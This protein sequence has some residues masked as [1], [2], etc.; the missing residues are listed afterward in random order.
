[1]KNFVYN[2]T[3]K[4]ISVLLCVVMVISTVAMP[5]GFA[6]AE[7]TLLAT[8]GTYLNYALSSVGTSLDS[9]DD[10][11]SVSNETSVDGSVPVQTITKSYAYIKDDVPRYNGRY[12]IYHEATGNLMSYKAYEPD[13]GATSIIYDQNGNSDNTYYFATDAE[14]NIDKNKLYIDHSDRDEALWLLRQ[15]INYNYGTGDENGKQ[16][17]KDLDVLSHWSNIHTGKAMAPFLTPDAIRYHHAYFFKGNGPTWNAN[18]TYSTANNGAYWY[19]VI[20]QDADEAGVQERQLRLFV[21]DMFGTKSINTQ[22]EPQ[23]DGTFIVFRRDTSVTPTLYDML[24]C[25]SD[26]NWITKAVTDLDGNTDDTNRDQYKLSFY[27]YTSVAENKY[28]NFKGYQNYDVVAGTSKEQVI[29]SIMDNITVMN[30]TNKNLTIPCSGDIGRV[31]YYW[32]DFTSEYDSSAERAKSSYNVNIKYRN[33]DGS[34]TIVGAVSVDVH[35]ELAIS[36]TSSITNLTGTT[37][38]NTTEGYIVQNIVDENVMDCVFTVNV[39]TATGVEERTVPVTIGMLTNSNGRAVSTVNNGVFENLTLTYMGET[40]TDN[41]T[42]V[43]D[44]SDEALNYPVYPEKGSVNVTKTG[45]SAGKFNET[46]VANINLSTTGV[47]LNKG[48]DMIV[49]MDL[50]G[51][52]SYGVTNTVRVD[53]TNSETSR[54]FALQESLK[55]MITTLKASDIDYRIAMSD[56]GDIDSYE[57]EGAVVDKTNPV[58]FFFD[59]D[60]DGEWDQK[61]AWAYGARREFY[62]HLNYVF[63]TYG[64]DVTDSEGNVITDNDNQAMPYNVHEKKYE[65]ALLNYSGKVIPN[66]YTGSHTVDADAFVDVDTFD[67]ATIETLLNDVAIHQKNSLGTNYDVGLEYAYQLGH[68]IQERNIANGEDRDIICIFMSDGAAMQYNYFSGRA[69]VQ[70]W[71]DWLEGDIDYSQYQHDCPTQASDSANLTAL[72]TTLLTELKKGTLENPKYGVREHLFND[73][74]VRNSNNASG[75]LAPREVSETIVDETTGEE[76]VNV[77]YYFDFSSV[78]VSDNDTFYSAMQEIG[79]SLY[80]DLLDRIAKANGLK[81]Y[82]CAADVEEELLALAKANELK[83]PTDQEQYYPKYEGTSEDFFT[84]MKELGIN[85]GWELFVQIATENVADGRLDDVYGELTTLNEGMNWAT[86]S[87]YYYFYNEDGK[88]WFAEA[89]KGDRSELYPVVNKHAFSN[90]TDASFTYYGDVRNNYSTDLGLSLDGKDYISGFRG[91]DIP[92]YTVGLSLCT[93]GYLSEQIAKSVLSNISSGPSY[94]FTANNK[95]ELVDVFNTIS[96]SS[97]V[98]ATGAYFTDKMGPEFDLYTRKTVVNGNGETVTINVEPQ[99]RVLEYKLDSNGERIGSPIVYETVTISEDQDGNLFVTSDKV[100]DIVEDSSG[101]LTKV[102][103]NIISDKG[104][105]EAKYFYYNTNKYVD[106][107]TTGTVGIDLTGDKIE[108]WQLEAETFFWIIGPIS[109]TEMVLDYQVYLTGSMEGERELGVYETNT[110]ATL[111]YV[112]YLGN[113]CSKDTVSPAFPWPNPFVGYSFYLVD[114]NGNPLNS[115]GDVSTFTDSFKITGPQYIEMLLNGA[116]NNIV[117]EDILSDELD[118]MY[119]I[120]DPA[121]AYEVAVN[122]DDTGYWDISKTDSFNNTTYVTNY[123]GSPTTKNSNELTSDVAYDRTVVWFALKIKNMTNPDTVVIDYGLPVDV[124]VLSNDALFSGDYNLDYI[125]NASDFESALENAQLAD[126]STTLDK[127]LSS[128]PASDTPLF[129]TDEISGAYGAAVKNGNN[130]TY[131]LDTS[132]GMQMS[133]EEVFV[134]GASYGGTGTAK[135]GKGYYYSTL[136][137]IPATS[138]YYEDNFVKFEA[139]DHDTG[140]KITEDTPRYE[141]LVWTDAGEVADVTQAQDRPGDYPL[142]DLDANNIY[143]YDDAYLSMNE[144]SLG[145]SK[146]I[147]VGTH[148]FE[149]GTTAK[150]RATASFTFRGTGFDIISLTSNTTGNIIIQVAGKDDVMNVNK[151]YMVDTYYGYMFNGED[152]VVDPDADSA[153]YQIPVMKVE[154]LPYGKYD[155]TVT[156]AYADLFDHQQYGDAKN[157]DFYFDAVRIYDPANDGKNSDVIKDAY[158]KDNEGW[159]MYEEVRNL[160]LKA[161]SFGGIEDNQVVNGAVFID[162][163]NADPTTGDGTPTMADYHNFGP[164]NELYLAPGQ[165]VAFRLDGTDINKAHLALKSVTGKSASV[166]IFDASVN[167]ADAEVRTVDTAT[168]LYYDITSLVD[169]VI[170]IYN[171]ADSTGELVSITNIKATYSTEPVDSVSVIDNIKM[172]VSDAQLALNAFLPKPVEETTAPSEITT[173]PSEETTTTTTVQPGTENPTTTETT[174]STETSEVPTES[175][176][177]EIPSETVTET[178]V[179]ETK[180]TETQEKE[181]TSETQTTPED[182]ILLGD[183]NLDEVINIKDATVIQKHVASLITLSGKALKAADYNCD[184]LVNVKDATGIQKRIAGLS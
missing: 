82:A 87:P 169:K 50:S 37:P 90:N 93:E 103:P 128:V 22:I 173:T 171:C 23:D 148:T 5:V 58:K 106:E 180:T 145:S 27:R 172:S 116:A 160:I 97:S 8:E 109:N 42:L 94:A 25:D 17:I 47:P 44:D 114:E 51:S 133:E 176:T 14:G 125:T 88:N 183:A 182:V 6:A 19:S 89:I 151:F 60:S 80:W 31:G 13:M 108:D 152:W 161:E 79:V 36:G 76:T 68:A 131:S 3:G 4:A 38:Q 147:N 142:K 134:Y 81:G 132:N 163:T 113:N 115:N 168:D 127:Y 156:V 107:S 34:D 149:D 166:K 111:R 39:R 45:T 10:L 121:A 137:V 11:I 110:S 12:I 9:A 85:C 95:E 41:F 177:T 135:T 15:D 18:G 7:S 119:E 48:V 141:D 1:M 74:G 126:S 59:G 69:T 24:Y 154:D 122:S 83:Y 164:N 92:I 73:S 124:D 139:F 28:V 174:A 64:E 84:A 66:I 71:A 99:I 20:G 21:D 165:A 49:V 158:I 162:N 146:F 35:D 112:N 77:K 155:V 62:N 67:D 75:L 138:I 30:T 98:A 104:I 181:T 33:D 130:I 144:Y 70:A 140:A 53:E 102:Y 54:L 56:F 43:V 157:Y 72:M 78:D 29:E 123:G 178:Q 170:V 159:P 2:A 118:L 179:T 153:L 120:Y 167:Q 86:L 63:G 175:N 136:T 52:M 117:P 129:T 91:L 16:I 40:V 96:T 100:Y 101:N 61:G 46:G 105:I 26:G 57:F 55:A 32:L 65:Q 143:G 150:N 184:T